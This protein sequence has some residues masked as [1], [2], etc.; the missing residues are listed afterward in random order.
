V[1]PSSVQITLP[2]LNEEIQLAQSVERLRAFLG[3]QPGYQW[4]IQIVDNGSTDRTWALAQSLATDTSES[5]TPANQA[6]AGIGAQAPCSAWSAVN[7][8]TGVRV[9][10]MRLAQPGRGRALKASWS[11]SQADVVAYMDI[12]LSTDLVHLPALVE[13]VTRGGNDL[14]VG[15]RL[16]PGA[17]VI[18][19]RQRE[20][21][22]R[23]YNRLVHAALGLRVHDAQC[24]F[25]AMSRTAARALLP[26]V[27]DPGWFFDTELLVLAQR[28]GLR[29]AEIPVRWVEDSDSRVRLLSTIVGD[30]RG[31]WR[32]RQAR[33]DRGPMT[34]DQ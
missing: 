21:L 33:A 6:A 5:A 1:K 27:E 18:R 32:L 7:R 22:S 28:R 15:S 26:E 13:A 19:S 29:I 2:V 9:G 25:K 12:D 17:Q 14:A 20:L 34:E 31:I 8:S 24:G 30:L 4:E 23:V 11:A 3:A 16:A 10:C